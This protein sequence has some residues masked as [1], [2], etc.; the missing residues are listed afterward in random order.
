MDEGYPVID[1]KATGRNIRRLREERG[2]T[3]RQV[4]AYF[5]FEM[6]QAVYKWEQGRTLPTIDNLYA[7]SK[8]LDVPMEEILVHR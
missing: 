1:Q 4:Q 6:P 2:L 5:G 3:V 7:L 8:L